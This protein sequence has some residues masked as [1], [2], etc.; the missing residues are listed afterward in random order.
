MRLVESGMIWC[1]ILYIPWS[2]Q[3]QTGQILSPLKESWNS[4]KD[5]W[6]PCVCVWGIWRLEGGVYSCVRMKW[7]VTTTVDCHCCCCCCRIIDI[8]FLVAGVMS[9]CCL[10]LRIAT[11]EARVWQIFVINQSILESWVL[12]FRCGWEY[13]VCTV[14]TVSMV[15]KGPFLSYSTL[16]REP[17]MNYGQG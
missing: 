17:S 2:P 11:V 6:V 10:L 5:L 14:S 13:T 8:A 15:E 12:C 9:F 4:N 7:W 1:G 3:N 16:L